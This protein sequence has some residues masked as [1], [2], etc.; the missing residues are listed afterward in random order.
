MAKGQEVLVTQSVLDRL[1]TPDE[2]W[3]LTRAH[4]LH[5]LRSS[6]KTN[7]EWLLNTRTPPIGGLE[8][9]RLARRTILHYGLPDL[10]S[11][12]MASS[13][14]RRR[15]QVLIAELVAFGEPR[16]TQVA[17][18]LEEGGSEKKKKLRF[19]IQAKLE[20]KPLAEEI[21]FD[22]VLDLATG[23]YELS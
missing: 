1:S 19:H 6:I 8:E 5:L 4:S 18:E 20:M 15:L 12:S 17:V 10:A 3:P 11:L 2:E 14:D 9:Y 23:Q 22:T 16:L 21:S 13:S 7:L